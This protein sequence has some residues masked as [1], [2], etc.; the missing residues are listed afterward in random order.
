MPTSAAQSTPSVSVTTVD[1][2]LDDGAI[3][4][5]LHLPHDAASV[6][7]VVC[8]PIGYDY[9]VA[10]RTLRYLADRIAE[11]GIPV[12][13]FDYPGFGDSTAPLS[14]DAF[15]QGAELAAGALRSSGCDSIV[16]LGLGSGALVASLAAA[17]D[18]APAGLVLWDPVSSGRQWMRR[19][20]SIYSLALGSLAEEAPDGVVEIAGAEMPQWFAEG[21]EALSY[22]AGVASRVPTLVAVRAGKGGVVPPSLRP[23]QER[24]DVLEVTEHEESLDVSSVDSWIPAASVNVVTGWLNSRFATDR[25]PLPVPLPVPV[26]LVYFSYEGSAVEERLRRIGPNDLFGIETRP[27]G[28]ADDLPV[29]ILHN[30][31]AEHRTGATRH[32]VDLARR[33]AVLGFRALRVDR[34]GTGE[35]G[36][37]HS[38]EPKMLFAKEWL[39]DGADIIADLAMPREKIGVAGMCVGSWVGLAAASDRV[40]FVAA[41]SVSDYRVRPLPPTSKAAPVA[42]TKWHALRERAIAVA[43]RR[44]PYRIMLALATRGLVQFVEPSLR[45]AL[46][47]GTDVTILL[48][49]RDTDI[50]KAHRGETAARRLNRTL[51]RLT[52]IEHPTGD[53]A[54]FSPGIRARAIEEALAMSARF[55]NSAS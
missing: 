22:D 48:S 25:R 40:A 49:P 53:H 35:T 33:L 24:C 43:K 11:S 6:G 12:I 2:W 44:A 30:G 31:S 3:L 13:R 38:E 54:L 32:Q 45:G 52:V 20:R 23:V 34:R 5:T 8:P 51:G 18:P 14:M 55:F 41:S 46:A 39:E 19:Q 28:G 1:T 4:A 10:Y 42:P 50:F 17:G 16:Y 9:T 7:V 47:A 26:D 29:V 21:I 37:V 15:G 36:E 27:A